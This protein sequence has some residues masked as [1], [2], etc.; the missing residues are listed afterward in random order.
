MM[1]QTPLQTAAYET[2]R[3]ET[4]GEIAIVT[5]NRPRAFNAL[6]IQCMLELK[7]AFEAIAADPAIRGVIVTGARMAFA[8][9][10][11]IPDILA[12]DTPGESAELSRRGQQL[13]CSIEHLGKPVIA[14]INALAMGGGL[15]LALACTLRVASDKATFA[16]PEIKLGIIPGYGGTQRL[17]RM[18]GKGRAMEMILTGEPIDAAEALRIGLVNRVVE[19]EKVMEESKA[20]MQ[21]LLAKAPQALRCA[22]RAVSE[23]LEG[24]LERGLALESSLFGLVRSTTDSTEGLTAFLEKRNPEFRGR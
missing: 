1:E 10:A 19:R 9:G 5:L 7:R 15:E 21:V 3:Y 8:M 16:L 6:N 4:D 2:I 12:T 13:F 14:A 18:I 20:L 24:S 11:D 23:G 22:M 17:P